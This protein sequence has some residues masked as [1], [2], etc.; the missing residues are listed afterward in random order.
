[1]SGLHKRNRTRARSTRPLRAGSTTA[2]FAS[3]LKPVASRPAPAGRGRCI[4]WGR[5]RGPGDGKWQNG[6][7][8]SGICLAGY[9]YAYDYTGEAAYLDYGLKV[10]EKTT[11]ASGDR[12]KTF[13]QQFRASPYFLNVLTLGYKPEAV[14][15]YGAGAGLPGRGERSRE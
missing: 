5:W 3:P 11:D 8:R 12:V 7:A 14:L 15:T 13:A 4:P 6:G 1:M 2:G 10:L 9:G